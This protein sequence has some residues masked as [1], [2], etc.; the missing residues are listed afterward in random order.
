MELYIKNNFRDDITYKS[1]LIPTNMSKLSQRI[2]TW[3]M[4]R[5]TISNLYP[6]RNPEGIAL[7]NTKLRKGLN[8]PKIST[9]FLGYPQKLLMQ[10]RGLNPGNRK[11]IPR[12]AS[13]LIRRRSDVTS[14]LQFTSLMLRKLP[15]H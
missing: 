14:E 4:S 12:D 13:G 2:L 3:F 6:L 8:I 5:D 9:I 7:P 15:A 1:E 10:F 11:A